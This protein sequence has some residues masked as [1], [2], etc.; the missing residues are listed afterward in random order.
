MCRSENELQC[1]D[2]NNLPVDWYVLYKLPKIAQSSNSVIR[3]GLAYLYITNNTVD[4]GW[5]LSR[6]SINMKNST[7]GNTLAPFYDDARQGN[8]L[9]MLYND[10][11]PNRGPS[12][13]Y[14]HTKGAIMASGNQGFWLIH[15]VPNFPPAPRAGEEVRKMRVD[16]YSRMANVSEGEYDYPSSGHNFGQSFLC[17]SLGADEFDTLGRQLMYNQIVVYKRNIPAKLG[18]RYP[19]LK[20]AALRKRIKD[21][22]YNSK[23][24]LTS[25]NSVEFISFAKS[26]KW[27]KDLYDDF[28]APQLHSNLLT[29]TWLNGR[30]KLPSDCVD[31]SK[32]YN[33]RSIILRTANVDFPSSRDHSKWA[34]TVKSKSNRHWVCIGDINRA[35]TQYSR[36][37]GAVCF[38]MTKVWQKYWEAV[39]D[40]EPC[41]K[42]GSMR[43]YIATNV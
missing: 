16:H 2:E 20:K 31:A 36:G 39:N 3:K 34:V 5:Q 42:A 15:S 28:I 41:P 18:K 32:V 1:R 14:G 37:G 26:D 24:T 33:V 17:I 10:N 35:E 7:P 12:A 38:D 8:K 21:Y 4:F 19:V 29:E 43:S 22:P 27:Q 25:I 11:P 23:A 9:W 40:I 13:K 6:A 30:G